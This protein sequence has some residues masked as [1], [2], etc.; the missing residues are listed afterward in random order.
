MPS[1]RVPFSSANAVNDHGLSA[2]RLSSPL[3]TFH[4]QRGRRGSAFRYVSVRQ[5]LGLYRGSQP[6]PE[7]QATGQK[8]K[9]RLKFVPGCLLTTHPFSLTTTQDTRE[10]NTGGGHRI[11]SAQEHH[12]RRPKKTGKKRGEQSH[13]V[14][15]HRVLRCFRRL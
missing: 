13:R 15:S 9:C 10:R 4:F 3:V 1:F 8:G 6:P 14:Q 11:F 5:S 2:T 7:G 12:T